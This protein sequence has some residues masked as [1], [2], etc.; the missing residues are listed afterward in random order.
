MSDPP[1][2]PGV[3][4]TINPAHDSINYR[5]DRLD[6]GKVVRYRPFDQAKSDAGQ[7]IRVVVTPDGA[8][9]IMRGNHRVYG[10]QEDGLTSIGAL[11]Y[12]PEQGAAFTEMPFRA[13]GTAGPQGS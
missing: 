13:G 7:P 3:P 4:G 10:A 1:S 9:V 2:D 11:L 5:E 8:K 6:A 12:T